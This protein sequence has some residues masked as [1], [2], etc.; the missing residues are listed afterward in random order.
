GLARPKAQWTVAALVDAGRSSRSCAVR[1]TAMRSLQS[2]ASAEARMVASDISNDVVPYCQSAAAQLLR[3]T[4]PN[5]GRGGRRGGPRPRPALV[6]R[7]MEEYRGI[8]TKWIVPAYMGK[9]LPR[10]RW[11]TTRGPIEL[12]LYAG[13]APLAMDAFEHIMSLGTIVGTEFSRVVPDFV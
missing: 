3:D 4:I 5:A 2:F 9:A 7:P 11:E 12:E 13:D 10:A 8:V 6:A 1:V